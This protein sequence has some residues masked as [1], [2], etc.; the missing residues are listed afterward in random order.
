MDQAVDV[1][2]VMQQT[3]ILFQNEPDRNLLLSLRNESY[4]SIVIANTIEFTEAIMTTV[5]PDQI[6]FMLILKALAMG[7]II[8]AAIFGNFLVI[9]SV[10]RFRRLRVI[11]NYFVV[12]LAFAD[13]L[14][15]LAVMTFNASV[16]LTGQ[17]KFGQVVCD[18]W[19]S[20]DVY[21]STVSILHLCCISVDRYVAIVQPLKYPMKMTRVKV[22]IMI[23]CVWSCPVL[24][25]FVPIFFGWYTTEEHLNQRKLQPD[26]CSWEVNDWFAIVSSS[27]SFWIPAFI[28]VC[29]YLRV[30]L[31]ADR[32]EKK[33][34]KARGNAQLLITQNVG[35]GSDAVTEAIG[36]DSHTQGRQIHKLRR[37]RK[38][39]KTLGIL[40]G[41]FL[42]CWLPFFLWYIIVSLCN[43]VLCPTP[44]IVVAILFWIGYLNS[45]LNP[46]IYA[47]FNR[48]FRNAFRSI[49][50]CAFCNERCCCRHSFNEHRQHSYLTEAR[51]DSVASQA[52]EH[53]QLPLKHHQKSAHLSERPA[54]RTNTR[55]NTQNHPE[56]EDCSPILHRQQSKNRTCDYQQATF[57]RSA[58]DTRQKP[59][60]IPSRA[61]RIESKS[62]KIKHTSTKISS[63]KRN[64]SD[65]NFQNIAGNYNERLENNIDFYNAVHKRSDFTK[66]GSTEI[67]DGYQAQTNFAID[68]TQP[69]LENTISEN[70]SI[71][72]PFHEHSV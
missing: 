1:N 62:V 33:L 34:F 51:R 50:M 40:M 27:I 52:G 69:L 15:A 16:Q 26:V 41:A 22:L 2:L 65:D 6:T 47:Y 53:L 23:A 29:M 31:E 43:D 5:P 72:V 13:M 8:A 14:V 39:M 30:F 68:T 61:T 36:D 54:L 63:S 46:L 20:L 4:S 35:H 57:V 25:S 7:S 17:W 38:A 56:K 10:M 3:V 12:S 48:D 45:T 21:F 24:I 67:N 19:N 60:P 66:K 71:K 59:V 32:Q 55:C 11:T 9:V 28:M 58:P 64:A 18:L 42:F 49:L 44:D 37:E 70:D